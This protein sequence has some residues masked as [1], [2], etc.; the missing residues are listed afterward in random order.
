MSLV[1]NDLEEGVRE[2]S[3]DMLWSIVARDHHF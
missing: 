3:F 1:N 2:E